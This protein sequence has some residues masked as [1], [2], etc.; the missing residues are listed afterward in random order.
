MQSNPVTFPFAFLQRNRLDLQM[1]FLSQH[2]NGRKCSAGQTRGWTSHLYCIQ[3]WKTLNP[4]KLLH[5]FSSPMCDVLNT[6]G[7][8]TCQVWGKV[9]YN[10]TYA[11]IRGVVVQWKGYDT[12]GCIS[13]KTKA[14]LSVSLGGM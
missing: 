7:T 1:L 5:N 13:P 10:S 12:E 9:C 6:S 8:Y 14:L 4:E 11:S 2:F 3:I